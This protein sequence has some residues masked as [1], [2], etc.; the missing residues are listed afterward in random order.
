MK[1]QAA[2]ASQPIHAM[3]I[4]IHVACLMG[5]VVFDTVGFFGQ[6]QRFWTVGFYTAAIGIVMALVAAIPGLIGYLETVPPNSSERRRVTIQMIVS[7][8]AVALFAA[9]WLNRTATTIDPRVLG[10]E[11][12][13][14]AVLCLGGWLGAPLVYRNRT[15]SN[16][17][18][19]KVRP[20]K[21]DVAPYA[22]RLKSDDIKL[23][24]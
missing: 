9:A 20:V 4:P 3:L 17:G 2:V 11:A 18:R 5:A 13:A 7:L 14:G 23:Q 22:V 24:A 15:E 19:A 1:S 21:R 16:A 6:S 10:L 8:T 12:M